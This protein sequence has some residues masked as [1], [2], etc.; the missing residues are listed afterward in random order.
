MEAW[1]RKQQKEKNVPIFT[2]HL[3]TW[4]PVLHNAPFYRCGNWGQNSQGFVTQ[5]GSKAEGGST[6]V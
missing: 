4:A 5:S 2:G 3:G 6:V 1:E